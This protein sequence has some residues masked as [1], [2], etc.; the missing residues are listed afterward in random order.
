MLKDFKIQESKAE[1]KKG[2][3]SAQ[4]SPIKVKVELK[5]RETLKKQIENTLL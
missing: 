3:K 2:A 1:M 5:E 4:A